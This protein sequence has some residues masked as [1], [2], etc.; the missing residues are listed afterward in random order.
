MPFVEGNQI[1]RFDFDAGQAGRPETFSQMLGMLDICED[2]GITLPLFLFTHTG[3]LTTLFGEAGYPVKF[4]LALIGRTNSRKTNLALCMTKTLDRKDIS[5]PVVNFIATECGIEKKIG[6]HP[7]SVLVIDDFMPASVKGKQNQLDTKLE[8][9]LRM[10]G[11][12][13]GI[14]RMTDFAKNP[15]AGYYPVKGV[16]I[17][18]GEHIR[19]VQSSLLRTLILNIDQR[20]VDNKKLNFY[21]QHP[22]ILNS[23]IYDF[24]YYLTVNYDEVVNFIR[25]YT[26][27]YR[28]LGIYKLPRYNEMYAQLITTAEIILKYAFD[29]GF[30]N[31]EEKKA[32]YSEW[33]GILRQVI[34]RN[35]YDHKKKDEP[36]RKY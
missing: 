16:G 15:G 20:S 30:I 17:V 21:Q 5:K 29:R 11:D 10:Y 4:V 31:L 24:L 6:L 18:T 13:E 33:D 36:F 26:E 27:E 34:G 23:H 8:K 28:A 12:R 25:Q 2:K 22:S 35:E 1:F 9:V 19:G 3:A 7:D 14:E 32:L